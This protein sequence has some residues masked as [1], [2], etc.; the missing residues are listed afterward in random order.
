[1]KQ[2]LACQFPALNWQMVYLWVLGFFQLK[3]IND[4]LSK[5]CLKRLHFLAPQ[6]LGL[7]LEKVSLLPKS[8]NQSLSS[9]RSTWESGRMCVYTSFLLPIFWFATCL[10]KQFHHQPA[11]GLYICVYMCVCV[12]VC[13]H[14]LI[15][16]KYSHIYYILLEF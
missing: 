11:M 3:T 12:F 9:W 14:I 15:L 8:V 5:S 16:P 2:Y 6:K 7:S 10:G 4:Y 13:I 1:M